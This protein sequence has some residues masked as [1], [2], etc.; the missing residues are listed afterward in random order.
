MNTN[1]TERFPKIIYDSDRK[2]YFYAEKKKEISNRMKNRIEKLNIPKVY[3]TLWVNNDRKTPNGLIAVA[4]DN[5][6][7]KQYYYSTVHIITRQKEKMKRMIKFMRV[8][9]KLRRQVS[10]DILS[11]RYSKVFLVSNMINILDK[12]YMRIGNLKYH[13]ENNSHGL[14]TLRMNNAKLDKEN[15]CVIFKFHGK[16]QVFQTKRLKDDHV[17]DFIRK[18]KRRNKDQDWLFMYYN[19]R[20]KKNV[21]ISSTDINEYIHRVIGNFTCKDYRTYGANVHFLDGLKRFN[22]IGKAY[23]YTS[24]KLGNTTSTLRNSYVFPCII[25]MYRVMDKKQFK[26]ISLKKIMK[27]NSK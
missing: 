25:D 4:L 14:T 2:I 7:R 3:L 22:S 20:S 17:Y 5:K 6:Q 8:L 9:P 1:F 23:N 21:R 26:S 18:L 16:H 13:H 15:K 11:K 24:E 27:D 12:T 19:D 10:A